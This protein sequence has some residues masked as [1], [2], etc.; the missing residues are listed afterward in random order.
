MSASKIFTGYRALGY[1][2]TDVPLEVRYHKKH[3]ENYAVTSVGRAFHVYNCSKLGIVSVSDI[4]P[5]P[6][7]VLSVSQRHIFTACD[8]TIRCFDK[9]RKVIHVYEGHTS[10]VTLL[11]PFGAHLVSVDSSGHVIVWDTYSEEVYLRMEFDVHSFQITVVTHPHGYTNKILMGSRQ[12]ALQLW[13]IKQNKLIHTFAGWGHQVTVLGQSPAVD[14]L[15]VGLADGKIHLHNFREDITVM[16]FF[17]DWGPVTAVSF[18]TDNSPTMVTG[19]AAGHMAVWNLESRKLISQQLEA[20]GKAVGGLHC[21]PQEPLMISNSGDN[22]LKVWIFDQPDGGVRLLRFREGH[23][24]PPN[25]LRHYGFNGQKIL[26]AGQD[27]TVRMFSTVHDKYNS[28]L[29]RASFNKTATKRAGLK[30]DQH[31]MPPVTVF[32]AESSR[33]SDWDSVVACHR[34]LRMVTTWSTVRSTM[35]KHKLD[36]QRFH[37]GGQHRLTTAQCVDISSCGNFAAIG[38]SSGHVDVYN[39]QS[40]KHRGSFGDPVAHPSGVRGVAFDAFNTIL[41]TAGAESDLKFWRFGSRDKVRGLLKQLITSA[42]ISRIMLHRDSKM[43]A[44]VQEDFTIA[45]IDLDTLKTVRAFSGHTNTITDL[46]FSGDGRWLITS[47]MDCTV[48]TWSLV[49]GRLIDC[50]A[51]DSAV[52]SL[53]MSPTNDFLA[54]SHVGDL[55]LYLWANRALYSFVSLQPLPED[56][57][58]SVIH[59]PAT[60]ELPDDVD[61]EDLDEDK[62]QYETAEFKSPEQISEDL[63]TLSQLPTSRWL[64][65]LYLDVIQLRNKPKEPPKVPKSAPFFLPTVAGLQLE[66]AKPEEQKEGELSKILKKPDLHAASEF[67]QMLLKASASSRYDPVLA[68]LKCQGAFAIDTDIRTL[69]TPQEFLSFFD[70]ALHILQTHRDFD[71]I[72]GYLGLFIKVHFEQLQDSEEIASKMKDVLKTQ[73]EA[74]RILEEEMKQALCLGKYMCS[75]KLG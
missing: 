65:L 43:L 44:V 40:G 59:M 73:D 2:S 67:G 41:I 48:R 25:F 5:G 70:F 27:S 75:A 57:R 35:G 9:G 23:S 54:T 30:H 3:K 71:L 36:S 55:G 58:A 38:Y 52:T 17:Q 1:V 22:T 63:I 46:T 29:G 50:F 7:T 26:C 31:K 24:A 21:L 18:R 39:L 72:S 69:E 45:V 13:N 10:A 28:S 53:S 16:S 15:A 8:N 51:V 37:H 32:A 47:S 19:S 34:G 12:G 56:H 68:K 74:A 11:L 61:V 64:S 14:V 4:H 6:I 33:E 62:M 60:A 49:H 66:F 42:R 20:H